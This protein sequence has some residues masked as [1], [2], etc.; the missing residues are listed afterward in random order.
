MCPTRASRPHACTWGQR[1][2]FG[3]AASPRSWDCPWELA[4]SPQ[5]GP[6]WTSLPA[7]ASL[8]SQQHL[9]KPKPRAVSLCGADDGSSSASHA[10]CPGSHSVAQTEEG[11]YRNN[12]PRL[13]GVGVAEEA[14][15]RESVIQGEEHAQRSH[16]PEFYHDLALGGFGDIVAQFFHL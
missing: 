8:Q 9:A 4:Q 6:T 3:L 7:G 14:A 5:Q 15:W 2:P 16:Q 11:S 1:R 10:A 13:Q 12:K